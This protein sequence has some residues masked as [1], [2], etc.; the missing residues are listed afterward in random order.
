[1]CRPASL[2]SH[3]FEL[4]YYIFFKL[5]GPNFFLF[6]FLKTLCYLDSLN[7]SHYG[8]RKYIVHIF[9]TQRLIFYLKHL[10]NALDTLLNEF[11][12]LEKKASKNLKFKIF[13]EL[14]SIF[15]GT[16]KVKNKQ[17]KLLIMLNYLT[18]KSIVLI[19]KI[20]A[21]NNFIS[22]HWNPTSPSLPSHQ[23]GIEK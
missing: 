13:F 1:M 12:T 15:L 2:D 10:K 4:F 8:A 18:Q 7:S 19:V 3:A 11:M 5:I 16:F 9:F 22:L 14:K 23:K 17:F 21:N 20:I 6:F